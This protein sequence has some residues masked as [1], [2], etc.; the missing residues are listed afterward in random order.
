MGNLRIPRV[1]KG[2]P[3]RAQ[4][5]NRLCG[6]VERLVAVRAGS[7]LSVEFGPEGL[8]I[9]LIGGLLRELFVPCKIITAPPFGVPVLPSNCPYGYRGLFGKSG[10]TEASVMPVYGRPVH[11]DEVAVYPCKVGDLCAIFRNPQANGS[12][13]AELIVLT[14][15]PVRG[16]C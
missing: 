13:K 9:G 4:D 6:M 3:I 12:K 5:W 8:I 16:P 11:N 10:V 14:E 1:R 15:K 7:G 2:E